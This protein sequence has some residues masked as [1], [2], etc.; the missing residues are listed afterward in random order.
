MQVSCPIVYARVHAD[1]A[2]VGAV[3]GLPVVGVFGPFGL[4][5]LY[6]SCLQLDQAL[7]LVGSDE[8]IAEVL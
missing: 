8:L 4:L 7:R 2:D 3:V 1:C 6:V 5:Q